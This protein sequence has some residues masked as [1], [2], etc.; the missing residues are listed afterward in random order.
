MAVQFIKNPIPKPSVDQGAVE[1]TRVLARSMEQRVFQQVFQGEQGLAAEAPTGAGHDDWRM[2]QELGASTHGMDSE[3][4]R[5][6]SMNDRQLQAAIVAA[7]IKAA[8]LGSGGSSWGGPDFSALGALPQDGKPSLAGPEPPDQEISLDD[9][10]DLGALS[11]IFESGEDGVGAVGYDGRGGT[12]YGIYQ[13]SSK[14]GT[15]DRF[16]DFLKER[17]P[18]WAARLEAAGPADTGS[19][20][21]RMPRVWRRIARENPDRFAALQHA[22]VRETH[23]E[24][25]AQAVEAATGIEVEGLSRAVK[26]V[27]WSTAVQHGPR[28]AARFFAGALNRARA[29]DGTVDEAALI[30]AVY[31]FRERTSGVFDG[32]VRRALLSRFSE[33]RRMALAML[34]GDSAED[35]A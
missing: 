3:R 26:E 6:C 23:Y 16:L 32:S 4:A 22:F 13:L 25:A 28:R 31:R 12:S 7:Y 15:M 20:D 33:E 9:Q 1:R 2:L 14:T 27:L 17:E 5:L 34:R 24:P 35:L 18:G 21:G 8:A 11:S 29:K 30:R 10:L 19:R